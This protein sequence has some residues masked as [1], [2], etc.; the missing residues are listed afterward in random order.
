MAKSTGISKYAMWVLMGLLI[1]ALGGFGA[2]NLSGNLRTL[3]SVGNKNIAVDQYYRQLSNEIRAIEAQRRETLPFA[4]AQRLGID[5]AVMQRIVRNRALDNE[6]EQVG[7]SVGDETLR[8]EI[9]QISAFQGVNGSF[10]REGYRYAL[11]QGGVSEA[12]FET[13]LREESARSLLQSAIL[14]GVKMPDTF[15][16]TLV[17]FAGEQ[18][19]F[20][21]A[22]LNGADTEVETPTGDEL[23]AYY[24]ANPDRFMLPASKSITYAWLSPDTMIDEVE[25]DDAAVRALYEER[26][27]QFNRPERRLV[28]RLVFADQATAEQAA[29][30][31]AAGETTFNA[32]VEG[33]GLQLADIDLGDV[34]QSELDGA[35]EAVFTAQAGAVVGPLPSSLGPALFRV[36][37]VLPALATAFEEARPALRDELAVASAVRAVEARA[38][39]LDDQLAGGVTL[40]ELAQS[41]QIELGQINWTPQTTDGIAAY[42][43]FRAEA[44]R[45]TVDDFPQI[46]QLADGG[47]FAMRLDEELAERPNPFEDATADVREALLAERKIAALTAKAEETIAQIGADASLAD[48]ALDVQTATDQTRNGFIDGTPTDFLQS[49]FDLKDGEVKVLPADDAVIIVQLDAITPATDN[50]ASDA[51]LEQVSQQIDQT[52]AQDLFTIFNDIIVSQEPPQI[53]QRALNAV[54]VNFP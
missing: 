33:R 22:I 8:E 3:G 36:N 51:L 49:V 40:E 1:L 27:T 21:Y 25:V 23:R 39:D 42:A 7:L 20:S 26:N 10:D 4:E 2:A 13:S 31:L 54:H 38:Q 32:L 12:E 43:N 46:K 34:G 52:L 18:R 17:N 53:D 16:Q 9:L 24:D 35:G 41:A 44:A 47:V 14:G 50:E 29:A 28:E 48:S 45:L 5:R 15:A 30:D 37:G 6:A 19:S 11:Q